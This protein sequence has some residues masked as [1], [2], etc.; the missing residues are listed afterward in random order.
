MF[1]GVV[2]TAHDA[3]FFGASCRSSPRPFDV[4]VRGPHGVAVPRAPP[5]AFPSH[6]KEIP[7][8]HT[9]PIPD[10][11]RSITPHLVCAGAATA[12]E[13]YKKAFGAVEVT[14]LPGPDG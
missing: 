7:M 5:S 14:R 4:P 12:I 3:I 11:F 6:I 13:F 9:Q 1:R 2:V 10:G 8:A